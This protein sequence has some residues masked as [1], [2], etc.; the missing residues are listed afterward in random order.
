MTKYRFKNIYIIKMQISTYL[1]K[2]KRAHT[3]SMSKTF[4]NHNERLLEMYCC[5]KNKYLESS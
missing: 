5:D 1:K 2:K 4:I 3:L